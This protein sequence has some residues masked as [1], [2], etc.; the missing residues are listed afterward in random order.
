MRYAIFSDVHGNLEALEA[1]LED[2]QK[3]SIDQTVFLGDAVGYGADPGECLKI[4]RR[5]FP[6][7]LAGNHDHAAAGRLTTETFNPIARISLDWTRD[8]LS[9]SAIEFL[10]ELPFCYVEGDLY[11]VH[12]CPTNPA[13]W[14]YIRTREDVGDALDAIDHRF[15]FVGHTHVPMAAARDEGGWID[16]IHDKSFRID[17]E[18]RYLINV[19]SVGQPRDG[20]DRA[21]YVIYDGQAS[22]ISFQRVPYDVE[23][24]QRKIIESGLPSFLAERLAEAR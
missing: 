10:A 8:H 23:K 7:I 6:I 13:R 17:R 24:S 16:S 3:K 12:A 22:T 20:N 14:K 1:V 21:C 18:K 4:I 15:C 5:E 11:F 19:G 9:E 2:A